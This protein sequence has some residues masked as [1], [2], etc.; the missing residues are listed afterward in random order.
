VE[1]VGTDLCGHALRLRPHQARDAAAIAAGKGGHLKLVF[2]V[3]NILPVRK[4]R[5]A[6]R[7]SAC[8]GTSPAAVSRTN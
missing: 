1:L 7:D 5:S 2:N 3:I 6:G 8:A 4:L